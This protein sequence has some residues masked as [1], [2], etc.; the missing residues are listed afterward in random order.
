[1][2]EVDAGAGFVA[3]LTAEPDLLGDAATETGAEAAIDR[4]FAF[5]SS[6][7]REAFAAFGAC[8]AEPVYR[9]CVDERL[10]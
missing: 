1:M 6:D 5:R 9:V 10:R 7:G 8:A 3:A 2:K 4:A